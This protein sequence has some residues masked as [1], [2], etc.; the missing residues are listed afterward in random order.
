[1]NEAVFADAIGPL[2][3]EAAQVRRNGIAHAAVGRLRARALAFA[4]LIT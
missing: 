3:D 2:D 1:M 4:K